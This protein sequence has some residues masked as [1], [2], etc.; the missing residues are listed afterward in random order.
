MSTQLILERLVF[1]YPRS[2]QRALDEATLTIEEGELLSLLGKSGSG[3]STL[4]RLVAGLDR[5]SSGSI[6]LG[7]EILSATDA[8][9][10]P[11]HRQICLLYT[12]DAADE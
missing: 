12:S 6:S 2:P 11:E 7:N 10:R 4:L 5:P 3:K 8:F 1:S 9:V